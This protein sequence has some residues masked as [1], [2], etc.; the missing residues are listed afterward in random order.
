MVSDMRSATKNDSTDKIDTVMK[1]MITS[2]QK[3]AF[4]EDYCK[5]EEE[6]EVDKTSEL[7]DLS[8]FMEDGIIKM[9]ANVTYTDILTEQMKHPTI[10]RKESRLAELVIMNSHV[11]PLHAGPEQTIRLV[12]N[13]F[14]VIGGKRAISKVISKCNNK[15]CTSNRMKPVLQLPP[16]LPKERLCNDCFRY[17]SID[18]SG[19]YDMKKCGL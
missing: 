10:L 8:P 11:T 12:R 2:D 9:R 18:A 1:L 15:E 19:P 3:I 13:R 17:I 14:W 4:G 6:D 16:P 5:L 7:Y